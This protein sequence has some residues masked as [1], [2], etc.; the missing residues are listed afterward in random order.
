VFLRRLGT[1][2]QFHWGVPIW[3][4]LPPEK[5]GT[6][7]Q[8]FDALFWDPKTGAIVIGEAKGGCTGVSLD[9]LLGSGYGV[10]QGT[11]D[12][13]QSAAQRITRSLRTTDAEVR[14]AEQILF[15]GLMDRKVPIRVEVFHT[16]INGTQSGVT[17]HYV[18]DSIR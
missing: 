15:E 5:A 1:G 14:Y 16:E 6:V 3:N 8:G 9:Q 11:I 12:W 4:L 13:V 2:S 10:R 7:P 17:R 18:S